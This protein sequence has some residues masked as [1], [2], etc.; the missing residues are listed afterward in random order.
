MGSRRRRVGEDVLRDE[1]LP[2]NLHRI[3]PELVRQEVDR[4]LEEGRGLRT[5]GPSIRVDRRGVRGHEGEIGCDARDPVHARQHELGETRQIGTL[6]G[7]G[8]AVADQADLQPGDR[9][10]LLG[11]DLHVLDLGAPMHHRGH[12]L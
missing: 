12:A 4:P 3:H 6:A 11:A 9:A 1:V 8:A 5:S 2:A 10:V 7:I